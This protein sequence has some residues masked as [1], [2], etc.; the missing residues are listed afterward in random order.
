MITIITVQVVVQY[1]YSTRIIIAKSNLSGF[2]Y[3]IAC[4]FVSMSLLLEQEAECENWLDFALIYPKLVPRTWTG[5]PSL[6]P[7]NV[8]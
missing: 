8:K 7:T 1:S 4:C 3:R 2:M 6:N 5:F